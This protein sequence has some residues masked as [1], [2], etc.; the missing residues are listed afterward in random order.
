MR[1]IRP[2]NAAFG[3]IGALRPGRPRAVV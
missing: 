2:K 1:H 3:S